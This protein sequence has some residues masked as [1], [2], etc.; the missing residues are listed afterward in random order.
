MIR[1]S[2]SSSMRLSHRSN[3]LVRGAVVALVGLLLVGLPG[4]S[5]LGS[6]GPDAPPSLTDHLRRELH[7]EDPKRQ[8]RALTDIVALAGCED[9]C[10]VAL[11]SDGDNTIRIENKSSVDHPIDLASLTPDVLSVYRN[12][13]TSGHRLL[14]LSALLK[15]GDRQTLER[16]VDL[17]AD[18][19]DRVETATNR[20]L[21][22]YYLERY[23]GL[24]EPTL[25]SEQLSIEEVRQA[26][27]A[28]KTAGRVPV[29]AS[30]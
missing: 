7:S 1:T 2:I 11:Q 6:P 28:R 15:I 14:A 13:P 18:Q 25:R 22:A 4:G 17:K 24:S 3:R 21:A 5:A 30:S 20:A 29:E 26:R 8:S 23:P 10:V 27:A 19:P 16:V 9:T 12:G